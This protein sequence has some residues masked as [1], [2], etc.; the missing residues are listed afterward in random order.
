[1]HPSAPVGAL[2][3]S[4]FGASGRIANEATINYVPASAKAFAA[5][6]ASL[7]ATHAVTPLAG[8]K[9]AAYTY[10]A[11]PNTLVYVEDGS[12]QVHLYADVSLAKLEKLARK[13]PN[14]R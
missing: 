14:F 13:L 3:C 7:G 6:E 11:A 5:V 12:E 8:I 2:I 9:T 10:R 1:M 4:Y